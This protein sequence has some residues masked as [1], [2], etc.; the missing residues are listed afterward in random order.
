MLVIFTVIKQSFQQEIVDTFT[1]T[2]NAP[3]F[4][5]TK[6]STSSPITTKYQEGW[7]G[8]GI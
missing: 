8:R 3:E 2:C 7:H 1:F 5:V 6:Y 4:Y